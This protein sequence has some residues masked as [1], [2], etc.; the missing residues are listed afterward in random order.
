MKE[1]ENEG[2]R[3]RDRESETE[4]A[5]EREREGELDD[6]EDKTYTQHYAAL[7]ICKVYH[8]KYN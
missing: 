6:G 3:E 8:L 5:R 7:Y 1:R 2:K 4:R